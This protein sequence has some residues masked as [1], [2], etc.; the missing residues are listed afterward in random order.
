M[1]SSSRDIEASIFCSSQHKK[2]LIK[3]IV[4]H[5]QPASTHVAIVPQG[6]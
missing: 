5:W 4:Q 6:L 3:K 1:T 2:L